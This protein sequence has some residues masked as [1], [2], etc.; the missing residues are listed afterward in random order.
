MLDQTSHV[1]WRINQQVSLSPAM[2]QI[3]KCA[4]NACSMLQAFTIIWSPS[5]MDSRPNQCKEHF[6]IFPLDDKFLVTWSSCKLCFHVPH[7][8][9]SVAGRTQKVPWWSKPNCV[10]AAEM[11]QKVLKTAFAVIHKFNKSVWKHKKNSQFHALS[12]AG[13]CEIAA[14]A[15]KKIEW[16]LGN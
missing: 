3:G 1:C 11:A 6:C 10:H 13:T 5:L 2:I 7:Q 12:W 4:E 16:W 8:N 9:L 14:G 15:R